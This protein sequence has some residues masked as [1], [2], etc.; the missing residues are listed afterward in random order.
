MDWNDVNQYESE[1]EM[2][3]Y[4]FA[5]GIVEAQL[6]G[7]NEDDG[8]RYADAYVATVMRITV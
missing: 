6:L 8:I 5:E 4:Y 1:Q 3:A 7:L 2:A